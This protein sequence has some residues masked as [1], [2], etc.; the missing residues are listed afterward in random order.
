[1]LFQTSIPP[2]NPPRPW[3]G[4]AAF[5]LTVLLWNDVFAVTA[6]NSTHWAF[7]PITT[8]ALPA[9]TGTNAIDRFVFAA[10]PVRG[11]QADSE[12]ARRT[13]IRRLSFDL[14]GLPPSP[15]EVAA[16]LTDG[17]PDAFERLVERFLASPHY[18]ERWGRHW[19]DI[20]AYADSNGYFNADSDRPLA[21]K[22]RDYVIRSLN[23]DKPLDRFIQE[24]IAGDELAGYTPGGDITP[25][26]IEPLT[27]THFWRNVPDGSGE[28]DGNPLEVKV[29]KYAVIEGNVQLLGSAFLGLT[30][31]CA[32]CHEHKFEPVAQE[33]YYALQAIL[34]PAFDPDHWLKPNERAVEAGTRAERENHHR[35]GRGI[36]RELKTLRESLDGLA[37]PFRRQLLEENLATLDEPARNAVQKALD[38]KEKD[39]TDAMKSLLKTNA[40]LVEI[41][42]GQ[43][44]KRFPTLASASQPLTERIQSREAAKLPPLERIAMVG[45]PTNAPPVHHL[46]IRGSHATEGKEIP[47]GVP[48]ALARRVDFNLPGTG[49]GH[50][51]T[52]G[53]RLALARWITAPEN[54]LVAR[55]LANRIWHFH[56]GQGIVSTIDNLGQSGAKPSNPGLLDWLAGELIRSGWSLKHLHRLIVTSA[57]WRQ[58]LGVESPIGLIGKTGVTASSSATLQPRNLSPR[59]RRLDAEALRDAMLTVSGELDSRIGGP[60]VPGKADAEGQIIIDESQ[61]GAHRRSLYLQQKR[62]H[63]VSLLSVFD[64]PAHNPV[65]IQRVQ[66]TVALQ[67]LAVL[68]SEFVRARAK[69]FARR[70]LSSTPTI[71]PTAGGGDSASRQAP[72]RL[73]FELAY[74]RPPTIDESAAA[75]GFL[76]AQSSVRAG[77]SDATERVWTDFCQMLIA[78]NA[79]LYVD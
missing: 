61:P 6:T 35:I 78:S 5:F 4:V 17:A 31:Q 11:T 59:S 39:R 16:F 30:L 43:L 40:P 22:Y 19:L 60:Y 44:H 25:E 14:R 24:Q 7:Q 37:A 36:E 67:S 26:M 10:L 68:N 70:V 52:S 50:P 71:S 57:A 74:G 76:G 63:P 29:D 33:D 9:D 46:F 48:P 47:P 1:M 28:S 73:A 66:S 58:G 13:V 12:S 54:P 79:F 53:R 45:E 65:C 77:E 27:A 21:W 3:I 75:E 15:G 2:R 51:A 42:A 49:H 34:R 64:G 32:R 69:A 62:T 18:G 72:L 8:P 20:V 38:T 56:F 23:A 55:V 41:T